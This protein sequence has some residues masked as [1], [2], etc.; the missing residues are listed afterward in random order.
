MPFD[1]CPVGVSVLSAFFVSIVFSLPIDAGLGRFEGIGKGAVTVQCEWVRDAPQ[2]AR[3]KLSGLGDFQHEGTTK[4]TEVYGILPQK[5]RRGAAISLRCERAER[6]R[7]RDI[8]LLRCWMVVPLA[9][10]PA[11]LQQVRVGEVAGG[12][13]ATA[14]RIEAWRKCSTAGGWPPPDRSGQL[15]STTDESG[16]VRTRV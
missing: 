12:A 5:K 8:Q 9:R 10:C 3:R 15:R 11:V 1:W 7:A 2:R 6:R 14:G 16:Q 4:G 13:H